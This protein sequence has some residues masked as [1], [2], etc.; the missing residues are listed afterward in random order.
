MLTIDQYNTTIKYNACVGPTTY[1]IYYTHHQNTHCFFRLASA[2]ETS[3]WVSEISANFFPNRR[4]HYFK[5]ASHLMLCMKSQLATNKEYILNRYH[6]RSSERKVHFT[7][8]KT[9]QLL[10]FL[11]DSRV[12][13][14]GCQKL[15]FIFKIRSLPTHRRYR[16]SRRL[17][18]VCGKLSQITIYRFQF[19]FERAVRFAIASSAFTYFQI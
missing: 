6:N 18:L 9:W 2:C 3:K 13:A 12:H 14:S 15:S 17:E 7:S 10:L 4:F 16:N 8:I 19:T 11:F 1:F 5:R